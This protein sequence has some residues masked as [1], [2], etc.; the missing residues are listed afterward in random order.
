MRAGKAAG[1]IQRRRSSALRS[2]VSSRPLTATVWRKAPTVVL[3]GHVRRLGLAGVAGE[4]DAPGDAAGE[5]R[6][7]H[8]QGA[9]RRAGPAEGSSTIPGTG[10]RRQH[11]ASAARP[12]TGWSTLASSLHLGDAAV[13]RLPADVGQRGAGGEEGARRPGGS[14]GPAPAGLAPS[15]RWM[16]AAPPSPVSS[17][18]AVPVASPEA[19]RA[20]VDRRA[21]A[22]PWRW[23]IGRAHQLPLAVR[24][25]P[26][27]PGPA[28]PAAAR[29]GRR[30]PAWRRGRGSRRPPARPRPGRAPSAGTATIMWLNWKGEGKS[31]STRPSRIEPGERR[32]GLDPRLVQQVD[33]QQRLVLAVPPEPLDHLLRRVRPVAADAHLDRHVAHLAAGE[34]GQRRHPLALVASVA[35]EP[36]ISSRALP[37]TGSASRGTW[38]R[39]P[40]VP[41]PDRLP[42]RGVPPGVAQHGALARRA[43]GGLARE[44]RG[45]GDGSRSPSRRPGISWTASPGSAPSTRQRQPAPAPCTAT[46]SDSTRARPSP[47]RAGRPGTRGVSR[48]A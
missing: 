16:N 17:R 40:C 10:M 19:A 24:A 3:H 22:P 9:A 28:P 23:R 34:V 21:A 39:I 15:W 4:G 31:R 6:L 11:P 46:R 25:P 44:G 18:R 5:R 35:R 27:P 45:R 26:A 36:A 38:V 37:R 47:A 14:P 13:H 32:I 48:T 41:A 29:R 33:E 2:S 12:A 43:A 1:S 30:S 7:H 20:S 42:A 8:R